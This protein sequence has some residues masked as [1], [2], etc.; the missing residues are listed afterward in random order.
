MQ[1]WSLILLWTKIKYTVNPNLK[2]VT[3]GKVSP[4]HVSRV[5]TS[6]ELWEYGV[7]GPDVDLFFLSQGELDCTFLWPARHSFQ[8]SLSTHPWK[9]VLSRWTTEPRKIE[10][11]SLSTTA[12]LENITF[13]NVAG[14]DLFFL[15]SY[16]RYSFYGLKILW[17]YCPLKLIHFASRI[18]FLM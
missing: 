10:R 7:P 2:K 11:T 3:R 8:N 14:N 12:K 17:K 4:L 18:L 16:M 15:I 13:I 6:N 9:S 5:P 1:V